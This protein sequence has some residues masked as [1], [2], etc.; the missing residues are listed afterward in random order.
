MLNHDKTHCFNIALL[1]I[2]L[3]FSPSC[4]PANNELPQVE[5][6]VSP[7]T[8][9]LESVKK[10]RVLR[11]GFSGY[12]PYLSIDPNSKLP[13]D[14]FS[15]ELV[16]LIIEKWD[17]NIE[18]QWVPTNW[19]NVR[20]DLISGKFDLIVEPVFRTIPR[21]A[22]VGFSRPYAEFAYAVGMVRADDDRFH[23]IK[24]LDSP[25]F[26]IC[27]LQG[28]SAHEY[29]TRNLPNATDV[30]ILS[31]GKVETT[32]DE[33]LHGRVDITLADL[34]TIERYMAAHPDKV[35]AVFTDPPP[36]KVPAGFMFRQGDH[37]FTEFLDTALEYLEAAGEIQ[38]LKEKYGIR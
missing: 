6:T 12:P 33:V 14:G 7:S 36:G 26:S 38:R 25:D 3:L 27:V 17:P 13:S 18:I 11:V 30:K 10:E 23:S 9:V 31:G 35:K 37:V 8:S 5:S 4:K 32:L 16:Q 20:L 24:Q 22:I 2:V 1:V 21:A 34:T 28:A 15:V 29:V 19:T